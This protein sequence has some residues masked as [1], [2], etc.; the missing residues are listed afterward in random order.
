LRLHRHRVAAAGVKEF[1]NTQEVA[2]A[3]T[4]TVEVPLAS[5]TL[6]TVKPLIV[7]PTV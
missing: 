4:V 2:S 3:A 7:P 6:L 5:T 1:G